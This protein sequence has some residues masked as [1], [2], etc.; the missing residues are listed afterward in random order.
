MKRVLVAYLSRTGTTEKMAQYIAEGVRIAGHD[1]EVKGI[2][3]IRSA[4]DLSGYDGYVFGSPTYHLDMPGSFKAFLSKAEEADLEGKVGGAFSSRTH[5]TSTESGDAATPV[6]KLMESRFK[7]KMTN[8]GPFDLKAELIET[9]EG[10]R[11]CQ[12]Y[13]RSV[14][15]LLND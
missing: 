4:Q 12:D 3:A 6:F 11:A 9:V 13:G 14:G 15:E 2:A 7:L 5:P 8:L 10:M 1:A